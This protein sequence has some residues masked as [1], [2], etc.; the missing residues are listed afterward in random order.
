MRKPKK[1]SFEISLLCAGSSPLLG[2]MD[3]RESAHRT[4]QFASRVFRYAV[5]HSYCQLNPVADLREV[6]A[7]PAV[8]S[9]AGITDPKVFGLLMRAIDSSEVGSANVRHGLQLLARTF[10]RPGELRQALRVEL[11]L[12]KA[13]LHCV[14]LDQFIGRSVGSPRLSL[15]VELPLPCRRVLGGGAGPAPCDHFI[16]RISERQMTECARLPPDAVNSRC[17]PQPVRRERLLRGNKHRQAHSTIPK[18]HDQVPLPLRSK[19]IMPQSIYP[20][21]SDG[22][23][24]PE[25]QTRNEALKAA[26]PLRHRN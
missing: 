22:E 20:A 10:V 12:E 2:T 23:R 13:Q 24:I 19:R 1:S 8:K 25:E 26:A 4:G 17:R 18:D 14:Q 5:Q 6:L 15:Q 16:H 21:Q 3:H 9:H 7:P 11:N